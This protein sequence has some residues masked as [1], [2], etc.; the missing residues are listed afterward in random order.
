MGISFS[1]SF[2]KYELI[3]PEN[4][5]LIT[6]NKEKIEEISTECPGSKVSCFEELKEI[7]ADL[8]IV[9]VKP[10]DFAFV[11]ENIPFQFSENQMLLS[12]MAGIKIEKIQKIFYHQK[13]VRA[14]PNSPTLLGMGITGIPL[15]REFL[16]KI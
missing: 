10:Q 6:R 1:K 9:A 14:M 16:F 4:L 5:H 2:L 15:Q 3:K 11:A 8:V 12:I 7:A 13:V